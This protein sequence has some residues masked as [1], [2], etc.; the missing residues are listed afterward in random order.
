VNDWDKAYMNARRFPR[1]MTEA[2]GPHTDDTLHPMRD[3]RKTP[4]HEVAL[5]LV[6]VV[7][8]V[9]VAVLA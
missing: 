3:N 7:A 1:S 6:A 9:V 2:F 4:A 5:Y 8:V